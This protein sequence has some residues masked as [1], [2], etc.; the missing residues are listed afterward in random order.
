MEMFGSGAVQAVQAVR[1]AVRPPGEEEVGSLG[2]SAAPDSNQ[3]R[4][5]P[6]EA[7]A[8]PAPAKTPTTCFLISLAVPASSL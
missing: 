8:A 4:A 7:P 5:G 3:T 6:R 2:P 1:P